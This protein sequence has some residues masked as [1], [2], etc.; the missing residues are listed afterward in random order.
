MMVESVDQRCDRAESA[1]LTSAFIQH[2]NCNVAP[3]RTGVPMR[4]TDIVIAGGGLAGSTAAAMLARDGFGVV[5]VDPHPVYPPDL[6]C[7]KLD[8]PQVERPAPHRARRRGA[9]RRHVRRRM[10]DRALRSCDREARRRPVR[11]PLRHAGQHHPRR[12]S[13]ERRIHQRQGQHGRE[14]PGPAGGH[15]VDRRANLRAAG[16]GRQRAQYRSAA[17]AR[18][19]ARGREPVPF[20]HHRVR[21]QAGRAQSLRFPGDDLLSGAR[22]RPD[23]LHHA[24]PD[25]RHDARE[26]HGLSRHERSV[27]ERDAAPSDAKRCSR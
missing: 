18:H 24:V 15:A 17:R 5:L 26:L 1:W 12:D 23:G 4:H 10:L 27:A 19:D 16:R 7:E 11:H 6:R 8:G 20:D 22:H 25:R 21:S 13:A 9:A 14:Q 2:S 3:T